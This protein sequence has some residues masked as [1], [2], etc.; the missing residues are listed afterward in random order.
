MLNVIL[1][2]YD[3]NTSRYEVLS[4]LEGQVCVN[5]TLLS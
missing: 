5:F 3:G 2:L 1:R 4:Y